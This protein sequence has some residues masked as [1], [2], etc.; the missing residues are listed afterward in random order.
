M[1]Y[2]LRK[3]KFTHFLYCHVFVAV[4]LSYYGIDLAL[5]LDFLTTILVLFPLGSIIVHQ[6]FNHSYSQFKNKF[7]EWFSLLLLI[8]YSFWPLREMK[9]YH[10]SHHRR[11]LKSTDPTASEIAQGKWLYYLG[12]TTPQQFDKV[13]VAIAPAFDFAAKYFFRIKLVIYFVLV[14]LFGIKGLFHIVIVPQFLMYVLTKAHDLVFHSSPD[15]Q[16]CAWLFPVYFN[17]SWHI[18]HHVEYDQAQHWHWPYFNLHFWY[19]NLLFSSDK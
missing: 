2:L 19:H 6:H 16:D 3:L 11:W 15:A 18:E 1:K 4:G 5:L 17:D 14:L 7:T 8:T 10:I 12:L 9:S 13:D